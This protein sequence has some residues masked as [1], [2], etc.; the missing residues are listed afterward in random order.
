[1]FAKTTL[2]LACALAIGTATAA[3]AQ[4]RG[5]GYSEPVYSSGMEGQGYR[6]QT[7]APEYGYR[8]DPAETYYTE[9]PSYGFWQDRR[10]INR[11]TG[12]Q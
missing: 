5:Y 7:A 9:G 10:L 1:M 3:S 12:E 4:Y 11:H 8:S 6:Y 2:A